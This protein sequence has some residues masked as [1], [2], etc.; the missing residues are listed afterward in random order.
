[1]KLKTTIFTSLLFFFITFQ[2]LSSQ[3]V[4]EPKKAE[5][6]DHV[7]AIGEMTAINLFLY[8]LNTLF[9][10]SNPP[11]VSFDIFLN[12]LKTP[13]VWDFSS[14]KRN[15]FFHPYIGASYFNAGRAN[16]LNFIQ[17]FLLA[18]AGSFMWEAYLEGP[19]IS[20]NDFIT[21]PL[22]GAILG[23]ILHR[24]Y[25]PTYDLCKPLSWLLSPMDALNEF[26]RGQTS[27]RP[28]GKI[29]SMDISVNSGFNS[30]YFSFAS[31]LSD[32]SS[33][34]FPSLGFAL[35]IVYENP[36]GHKTKEAMDQFTFK[37][38]TYGAPS[39]GL[40]FMN[41]DTTLYSVPY[42]T[43]SES[44]K[45]SL[46][47]SMDYDV[48]KSTDI[49]LSLSSLGFTDKHL[50]DFGTSSLG[51]NLEINFIYLSLCDNYFLLKEDP[52]ITKSATQ[53]LYTYKL[54]AGAK[55]NLEF[56]SQKFN[57]FS[58]LSLEYLFTYPGSAK[59]QKFTSDAFITTLNTGAEYKI[60]KNYYLGLNN[61]LYI[62][63]DMNKKDEIS[64]VF[65]VSDFVS[66][67][68][69]YYFD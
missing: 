39:Y 20:L 32:Y 65:Q 9:L 64:S 44:T 36:Y 27:Y 47:I 62:K 35:N 17:S 12:N 13:W 21:T 29:Y 67:Y 43:D 31:S 11:E 38:G 15:Q 42:F 46:G 45:N 57:L 58:D 63:N 3:E 4:T 54:G 6:K 18:T 7:I 5:F 52:D 48:L 14:F 1:M 28:E 69:K 22:D 23:E 50:F 37:T 53:P 55:I 16:N 56:K 66:L 40:L 26:L 60:Y 51:T 8:D 10:E 68:F 49:N 61:F 34:Y 2:P 24:L 59:D 25:F 19:V 41:C 33:W 30:S